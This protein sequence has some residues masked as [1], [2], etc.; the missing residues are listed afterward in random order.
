MRRR[1]RSPK[2]DFRR[3]FGKSVDLGLP[4]VG[5]SCSLPLTNRGL[6]ARPSGFES[7]FEIAAGG[8]LEFGNLYVRRH[9]VFGALL[10]EIAHLR[11]L[12]N[13]GSRVDVLPA[14][15]LQPLSDNVVH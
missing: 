9:G 13:A 12:F 5:H 6:A 2:P 10:G 1:S 3:P 14:P 15:K 11:L 7:S 8:P 4:R